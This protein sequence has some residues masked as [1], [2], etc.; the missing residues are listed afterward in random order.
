MI[1]YN[2][3]LVCVY[4]TNNANNFLPILNLKEE[5]NTQEEEENIFNISFCGAQ[6]ENIQSFKTVQYGNKKRFFLVP[7]SIHIFRMLR[8]TLAYPFQTF[9]GCKLNGFVVIPICPVQ[10][11]WYVLLVSFYLDLFVH[12]LTAKRSIFSV[13]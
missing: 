7:C 4:T 11:N 6:K 5:I 8:N 3:F 13:N 2:F 1:W 9:Y 10:L 12:I